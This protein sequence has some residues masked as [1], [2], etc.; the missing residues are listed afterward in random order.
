MLQLK[1]QSIK[2]KEEPCIGLIQENLI[3]F[4]LQSVYLIYTW[5]IV[6]AT[7][8]L[9]Y[10]KEHIYYI[11]LIYIYNMILLFWN[12]LYSSV[13]YDHDMWYVTD[14]W[15]FVIVTCNVILNLNPKSE[16]KKIKRNENRWNLL[17]SILILLSLQG[18]FS[19]ENN[20]HFLYFSSNSSLLKSCSSTKSNFF[21]LLTSVLILPSNSAT[22]FFAFSKFSPFSYMLLSTINLFYDTKYFT[23]SL[24]LI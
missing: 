18:F 11:P 6:Y 9:A 15:Q 1:S 2:T 5:P 23:T 12:L 20:F 24:S 22:T 7:L 3:E 4:Q 21:Y 17:S 16:N 10:F 8:N 19:E 13:T 14:V